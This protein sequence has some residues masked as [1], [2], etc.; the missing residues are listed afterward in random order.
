MLEQEVRQV[1]VS[2]SASYIYDLELPE[3]VIPQPGD[4]EAVD[5]R[6]L[7]VGE[8]QAA[9]AE[10]RFKPNCALLLIEFLVRHG[11]VTSE[12]EPDYIEIV[13]RCHRKLEFPT[14]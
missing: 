5:F 7:S 2:P 13:A 4:N 1:F 3:E 9:M 8:V 12:N 10:G 11:V 6:L 14:P